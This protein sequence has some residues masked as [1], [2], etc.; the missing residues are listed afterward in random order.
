M[1][2]TSLQDRRLNQLKQDIAYYQERVGKTTI[3]HVLG[4]TLISVICFSLTDLLF[5]MSVDRVRFYQWVNSFKRIKLP[6]LFSFWFL[7]NLY[8][9]YISPRHTLKRKQAEL[10][11]LERRLGATGDAL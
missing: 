8:F 10:A 7:F 6:L 9:I 5:D 11:D 1:S 2:L 4:F 3:R